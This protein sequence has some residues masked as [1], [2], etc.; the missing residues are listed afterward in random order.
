MYDEKKFLEFRKQ[1]DETWKNDEEFPLL[2]E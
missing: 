2:E 1:K